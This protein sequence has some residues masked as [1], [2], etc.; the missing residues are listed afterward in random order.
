MEV[1]I[2]AEDLAPLVTKCAS[3]A[4]T[5]VL[6]EA[7]REHGW[8]TRARL[9]LVALSGEQLSRARVFYSS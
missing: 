2:Q 3:I 7:G 5:A 4:K 9:R 6:I 1:T 8:M